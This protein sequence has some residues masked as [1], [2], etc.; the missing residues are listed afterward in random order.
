M[1]FDAGYQYMDGAT[2]LKY[3][4]TRH[5]DSDFGR[6]RRQQQVILAVRQQA[7]RLNLLPRLPD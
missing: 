1:H 3:A 7:L 2:A 5:A 4:R 6:I